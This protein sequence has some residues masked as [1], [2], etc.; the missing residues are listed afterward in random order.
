MSFQD[1]QGGQWAVGGPAGEQWG[2]KGGRAAC[3]A[4]GLAVSPE[5][6][7]RRAVSEPVF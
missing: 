1:E 5:S 4:E 6:A 2:E 7:A 3:S